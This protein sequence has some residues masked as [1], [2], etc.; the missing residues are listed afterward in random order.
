[1]ECGNVENVE[2]FLN[3]E[4]NKNKNLISKPDILEYY[5]EQFNFVVATS[6]DYTTDVYTKKLR[7]VIKARD[8]IIKYYPDSLEFFRKPFDDIFLYEKCIKEILACKIKSHVNKNFCNILPEYVNLD[9]NTT[10]FFF[11]TIRPKFIDEKKHSRSILKAFVNS[12]F[13]T[14]LWDYAIGSYEINKIGEFHSLHTH[15]IATLDKGNERAKKNGGKLS[16][17]REIKR[18][19]N[20]NNKYNQLF[21]LGEAGIDVQINKGINSI[22]PRLRYIKGEKKEKNKNDDIEATRLWR[23]EH[24]IAPIYYIGNVEHIPEELHEV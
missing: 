17:I 5:T 6:E 12:I 22:I 10:K 14:C 13:K 4:K 21:E 7:E 23:L 19:Y 16:I 2:G 3:E 24:K 11:I 8:I 20:L 18:I 9:N 1:M 15:I